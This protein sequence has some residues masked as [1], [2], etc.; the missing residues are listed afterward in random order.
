LLENL[1]DPQPSPKGEGSPLDPSY[2][3]EFEGGAWIET[4]EFTALPVAG[5]HRTPSAS[6]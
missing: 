5:Q 4:P 1:N 3:M 6:Q 2:F